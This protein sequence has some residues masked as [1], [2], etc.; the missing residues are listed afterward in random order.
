MSTSSP[1][2]RFRFRPSP[3]AGPGAC[4]GKGKVQGKEVVLTRRR[5]GGFLSYL[6]RIWFVL[7]SICVGLL[8]KCKVFG[9]NQQTIL[10]IRQFKHLVGRRLCRQTFSAFEILM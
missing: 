10:T 9:T 2:L 1:S 6:C 4:P 7:V 8:A 5:V 3:R